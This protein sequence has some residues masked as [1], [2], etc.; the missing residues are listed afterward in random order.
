MGRVQRPL[1]WDEIRS[2]A[3]QFQAS[4]RDSEDLRERSEA[5]TFWNEFFQVFGRDRRRVRA[6]FEHAVVRRNHRDEESQ[7][8]R[9]WIDL[10]WEGI[11]LV[12]H[13]SPGRSLD[14]AFT[15]ASDYW[16]GL[17]D[18]ELPRYVV[19]SDFAR[20]RIYDLEEETETEFGID[21][22][23]NHITLFGFI[24]GYRAPGDYDPGDTVNARA[25]EMMGELYDSI[26]SQ[27]YPQ[28]QIGRYMVRLLFCLYADDSSLFPQRDVF[29]EIIDDTREEGAGV[30]L[31]IQHVFEI[32]NTEE[33]SRQQ[34][35]HMPLESLPYVGG[36]LFSERLQTAEFNSDSRDILLRCCALDWNGVSP[37]VF[38]SMFQCIMDPELRRGLGA[39]YTS[40]ENILKVLNGLFLDDLRS[41]LD[42][43]GRNIRRLEDLHRRLG[44]IRVFDPA[45]GCGNFLAIAYREL[46][47]IELE[48]LRRTRD[49]QHSV[50]TIES[51]L[52]INVDQFYGIE[53][54]QYPTEIARVAL[55]LTD[56]IMNMEAAN[57]FGQYVNRLPLETLPNIVCANSLEYD[58]AQLIAPSDDTY[59]VGNPPFIGKGNL[60]SQQ[61]QDRITI[62]DGIASAGSLDYV[63]CWYIRA[64]Q[65]IQNT[66][67]K[68][69]FVA[70]N[71]ICQGEQVGILFGELLGTYG[72]HLHFAH[73][74]FLWSSEMRGAASVTVVI[75]GFGTVEPT[76]RTI[77]TY[78]S[79]T[80]TPT[81]VA[82][83]N[84]S[85]YLNDE[86]NFL[87]GNLTTPICAVSNIYWGNQAND[88][89][90]LILSADERQEI[91]GSHPAADPYI[92]SFIGAR[93]YMQGGERHCIWLHGVA[94]S[95]YS[96]ITPIMQRIQQV[97]QHRLAS[98]RAATRTLAE[99]PF[100]FGFVS[101]PTENYVLI[102]FH[103]SEN[104]DYIPF[105][106]FEPEVILSNSCGHAQLPHYEFGVLQS[107]LHMAWVWKFAGRIKG[108]IRYSGKLVYNNFP[109]PTNPT[110][111]RRTRV[112]N[113]AIALLEVRDGLLASGETMRDLYNP[114]TMP[115]TLREA[116]R[117][118][119]RS[120]RTL[121]GLRQDSN[122]RVILSRL[123]QLHLEITQPEEE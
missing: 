98:A 97:R 40:E 70:T 1:G 54:Q 13:K 33:D 26:L 91:I 32:L 89:G 76:N 85:P 37:A 92:R 25:A 46:R 66:N 3:I 47:M 80:A 2:R 123:Q 109:W 99:T 7:G 4:W 31:W 64:A 96:R 122:R 27:G 44:E 10:F 30:G 59:V 62:T 19:V 61:T 78:S 50:T 16:Q 113:A 120:V 20:F 86:E 39:H 83:S 55:W 9:G 118:L 45:C 112:E 88:G 56:H 114:L 53:I 93:E 63:T 11:L 28:E 58:W 65:Y 82:A 52:R 17:Q 117:Q 57:E 94:P 36:E 108:D 95:S 8:R 5:Q 23:V 100:S 81:S 49:G 79:P 110:Q 77:H 14:R 48:I 24:A 68:V 105:G 103:T 116:H 121:Y 71:S 87:I 34:S 42:R 67:C 29:R 115:Q 107:S 60:N 84:I 22:L 104:R 41:E 106:Y 21:E 90:H 74:S 69:G 43:I 38:G 15:Q 72:I 102:P 18:H 101:Q 35:S 111:A 73:Q 12:E 6:S 75:I 51:I 119:D